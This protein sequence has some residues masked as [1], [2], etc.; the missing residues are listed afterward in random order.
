MDFLT[1]TKNTL[2]KRV[3]YYTGKEKPLGFANG[4]TGAFHVEPGGNGGTQIIG[5]RVYLC[6]L[7]AYIFAYVPEATTL[8]VWLMLFDVSVQVGIAELNNPRYVIRVPAANQP[9]TSFIECPES[10]SD[11]VTYD[12]ESPFLK[13]STKKVG[14]YF[15]NGIR[16]YV[17]S[18]GTQLMPLSNWGYV[19]K[20]DMV[21]LV[22]AAGKVV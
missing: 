4:S 5:G 9:D 19:P 12:D 6:S 16:L 11:E 20:A 17:S 1:P 21:T 15:E 22:D 13:G 2:C 7:Y 3:R 18:S 14:V 10:E 8:D